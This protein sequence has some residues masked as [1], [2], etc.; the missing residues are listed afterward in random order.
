MWRRNM[1]FANARQHVAPDARDQS[2][3]LRRELITE[4]RT[5]LLSSVLRN[6]NLWI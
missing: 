2:E 4:G 5:D 3:L 6:P 1:P